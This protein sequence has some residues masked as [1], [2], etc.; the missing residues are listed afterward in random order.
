MSYYLFKLYTQ[1]GYTTKIQLK[2]VK[3][4]KFLIIRDSTSQSC[5]PNYELGQDYESPLRQF[6]LSP[7]QLNVTQHFYYM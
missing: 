7:L 2:M 6:K 4:H 5:H 3:L 1:K